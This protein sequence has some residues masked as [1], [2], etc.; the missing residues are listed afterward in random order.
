[1]NAGVAAENLIWIAPKE[2]SQFA[3]FVNQTLP[4]TFDLRAG[5]KNYVDVEVLCFDNREVNLYGYQ[6][7]DLIPMELYEFCVFAN[8]CTD[9]GRH[10]S[11]NYTLD[12]TYVGNGQNIPIYTGEVPETGNTAAENAGEFYADPLCLAIP[13]P[14]FGEASD[15]PYLRVT[16]TLVNWDE[17]YPAPSGIEPVSTE[18]S[19]DDVQSYFVGEDAIDYWHIFFNCG[20]T[21]CD[22]LIDGDC[23]GFNDDTDNCP[24]VYNPDQ[25][26]SDGDGIGDACDNCVGTP[27]AD[28][29]DSDGDG[30][31][32]VC[33][34]CVGT[35]NADQ[36]DKDGDGIG[37]ACDACPNT[38]ADTA[39]GCPLED[40]SVLD[41]DGG[42]S[43]RL[44]R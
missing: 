7:F 32:D 13:G 35:P 12:I 22:P 38:A 1:M 34:N 41:T 6:F 36:K 31:G 10:Y 42:W 4:Y 5:S 40:C 19:W 15:V 14:Q 17:N 21:E 9:A 20:T 44:Y 2:G 28:Q 37:D 27:N 16:A 33:D 18:L 3:S 43:K 11:A 26:D 8:Y 30:V 25:L 24:N 23:D 39:D 29:A